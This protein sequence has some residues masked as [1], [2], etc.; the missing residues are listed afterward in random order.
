LLEQVSSSWGFHHERVLKHKQKKKKGLFLN[1]EEGGKSK[2]KKS[3]RNSE[4][5]RFCTGGEGIP[6]GRER[7]VW[8]PEVIGNQLCLIRRRVH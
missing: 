3:P 6:P 4:R 2:K 7:K 8:P 1:T 5:L